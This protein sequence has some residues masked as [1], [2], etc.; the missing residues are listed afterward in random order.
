MSQI[1]RCF[2]MLELLFENPNGMSLSEISTQTGIPMATAHRMLSIVRERGY[3]RQ[4][5]REIYY[6]TLLLPSMG[7][8]FIIGTGFAELLQ[9]HLDA[10][11]ESTG[12]HVRLSTIIDGQLIWVLR[13]VT[14]RHGLQYHG[15]L[16]TKVVPHI[17]AS[18]KMWLSTLS[19]EEAMRVVSHWDISKSH[20]YGGPN[21]V[22]SVKALLADLEVIR[23]QGHAA[24]YEEAELGVGA[25]AVG[26]YDGKARD[27]LLGTIS[28]AGPTVRLNSK[29]IDN[30]VP[31]LLQTAEKVSETWALWSSVNSEP[32]R[33]FA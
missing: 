21:A 4:D 29:T 32:S 31:T 9:P 16:D 22:T 11:A 17:T 6:L 1:N 19:D 28:I 27:R 8:H 14:S 13:A 24:I 25:I 23:K 3:I 26:V 15:A 20:E 2:D 33:K 30:Y 5:E 7:A 12:E 18:G 10:L